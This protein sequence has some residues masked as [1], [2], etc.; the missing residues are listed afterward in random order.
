MGQ[1][2]INLQLYHNSPQNLKLSICPQSPMMRL[3]TPPPP[4]KPRILLTPRLLSLRPIRGCR[5]K[6]RRGG[7][8]I[9]YKYRYESQLQYEKSKSKLWR[10]S[11]YYVYFNYKHQSKNHNEELFSTTLQNTKVSQMIPYL[12]CFPPPSNTNR[13]CR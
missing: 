10:I 3:S 9:R 8:R 5:R 4:K 1:S 12:C 7:K 6:E 11:L 2:N 13:I